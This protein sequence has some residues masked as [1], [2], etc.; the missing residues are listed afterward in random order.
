MSA[1][2]GGGAA[3]SGG[4]M[5]VGVGCSAGGVGSSFCASSAPGA[6]GSVVSIVGAALSSG[7]E[8][9]AEGA[10][11]AGKADGAVASNSMRCATSFC[12]SLLGAVSS[13]TRARSRQASTASGA[14]SLH[15]V[16]RA[17]AS[18]SCARATD[19]ATP[20]VARTIDRKIARRFI[21]IPP[22]TRTMP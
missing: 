9:S 10:G 20:V 7:T 12:R 14:G 15:W 3:L 13:A 4:D 1:G 16:M 17:C 22:G 19:A 6:C 18:S 11:P 2:L 21:S 8:T 5:S